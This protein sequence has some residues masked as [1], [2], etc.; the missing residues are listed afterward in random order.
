MFCKHYKQTVWDE[1][2]NLDFD[3]KIESSYVP[4]T[5]ESKNSFLKDCLRSLL[6][7]F[8]FT[9]AVVLIYVAG[10]KNTMEKILCNNKAYIQCQKEVLDPHPEFQA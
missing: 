2:P 9:V 3:A 4:K 6:K 1:A 5:V 10:L 7:I 8:K